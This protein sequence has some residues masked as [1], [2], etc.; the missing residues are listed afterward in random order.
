FHDPVQRATTVEIDEDCAR[1]VEVRATHAR[2]FGYIFEFPIAEIAIQSIATLQPAKVEVAP[3]ISIDI[4]G[5]HSRSAGQ[6]L[7]SQRA[8]LGEEVGKEHAGCFVRHLRKSILA[9]VR[10]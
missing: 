9:D 5:G 8:L 7:A 2:L 10:R 4:P 6:N 1:G 3:A